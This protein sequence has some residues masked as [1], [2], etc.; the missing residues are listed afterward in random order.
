VSTNS[1]IEW[2]EATWNPILG[3]DK[4]SPGCDDC[5]AIRQSRMRSGN[6]NP[7]IRDAYRGIV[8]R[9]QAG[10]IDWTG[11]IN[12]LPHRLTQP[13]KWRQPKRIFV[14]SM[15]DLFHP[16]VP[17]NFI[18]QVFA[19]MAQA[20]HHTFQILTKRHARMRAFLTDRCTC[21]AGHQPGEHLRSMMALAGVEGSQLHVP[22]VSG[23]AVFFERAWPLDNVW[24]GVSVENQKWANT[25]IPVLLDTPAAVRWLSCE[26]LIGPIDLGELRT[27]DGPVDA[28]VGNLDHVRDPSGELTAMNNPRPLPRIDWVVAGGETGPRAHPMHPDWARQLRDQTTAAGVPFHFKQWGDWSPRNEPYRPA[29][30]RGDGAVWLAADG[31][32]IPWGDLTGAEDDPTL[33]AMFRV[34]KKAA[35]RELDFQTWDE[36]PQVVAR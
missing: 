14:N 4:V 22:G 35:G 17:D 6:P 13:L 19:V 3:C 27:M 24:I 5:Y 12:L 29:D 21:G 34:G 28:L 18:T 36:Y 32:R 8:A 26:P 23:Q 25:R 16:D 11:Q 9:N 7:N 15:S 1:R 30:K 33:K 2:T 10:E 31:T 20:Q